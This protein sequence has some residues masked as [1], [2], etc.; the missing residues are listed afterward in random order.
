MYAVD[1]KTPPAANSLVISFLIA[2]SNHPTALSATPSGG[3]R[4]E[5]IW[6]ETILI[7]IMMRAAP[8]DCFPTTFHVRVSLAGPRRRTVITRPWPAMIVIAPST[9]IVPA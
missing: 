4:F 5:H 1:H 9:R 3:T 8:R 6:D 7:Q 2:A